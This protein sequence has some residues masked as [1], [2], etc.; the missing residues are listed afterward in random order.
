[1]KTR[2]ILIALLLVASGCANDV[3]VGL[4]TGPTG[5][6]TDVF[7]QQTSYNREYDQVAMKAARRDFAE[8][9]PS[10]RP[11]HLYVQKVRVHDDRPE[12]SQSN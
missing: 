4:Q 6:V 5:K 1:M 3:L 10:P 9:V 2:S 7:V 11:N 8:R 12:K